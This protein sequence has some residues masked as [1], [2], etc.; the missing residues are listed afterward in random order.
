M[1]VPQPA[2]VMNASPVTTKKDLGNTVLLYITAKG[3]YAL[4]ITNENYQF[5]FKSSCL[6]W[7]AKCLKI[8]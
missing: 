3:I 8:D 1:A 7:V 5:S 2:Q 6:I 4:N